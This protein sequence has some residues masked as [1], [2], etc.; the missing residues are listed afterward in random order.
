MKH[1]NYRGDTLIEVMLSVAVFG[2]ASM[3]AIG[4]M[5]RGINDSQKNLELTMARNEIDAQ[6]EALRFIHDAYIAEKTYPSTSSNSYT[7]VWNSIVSKVY[8]AGTTGQRKLP[9]DFYASYSIDGSAAC[10]DIFSSNAILDNSFVIDTH[11]LGES[12]ISS[13]LSSNIEQTPTYP[14]LWYGVERLSEDSSTLAGDTFDKA[15]GIWVTAVAPGS[16]HPTP[17]YYDFY[18]RTCW[19]SPGNAMSNTISTTIRLYNPDF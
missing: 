14:R 10:S 8:Y 16:T 3:G 7:S 2:A 18:I 9:N 1:K 12:S 13:A 19:D 17:Q 15:Q 11:S 5:N 6:A 4:V